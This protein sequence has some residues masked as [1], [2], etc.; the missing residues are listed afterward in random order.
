MWGRFLVNDILIVDNIKD[1]AKEKTNSILLQERIKMEV[2]AKKRRKTGFVGQRLQSSDGTVYQVQENGA[3]RRLT[4]K[5]VG[6]KK[7]RR[8]VR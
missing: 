1:V 5:L 6:G 4:P 7:K 8:K 3:F 2:L